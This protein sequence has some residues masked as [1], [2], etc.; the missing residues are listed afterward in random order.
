[1]TGL[2]LV[3]AVMNADV[4]P[5][6]ADVTIIQDSALVLVTADDLMALVSILP[7]GASETLF[8]DPESAAG[9]ALQHHALLTKLAVSHDL[10]PIRLGAIY[11]DGE[12]VKAML[13][14]SSVDF[15]AALKRIAG[16]AEFAMKLTP[17]GEAAISENPDPAISGRS[18]LQRRADQAAAQRNRTEQ[19]RQVASDA[20]QAVSSVALEHAFAPPRRNAQADQEKR[21]LDAA[22]LV[23]R[24]QTV[25]FEAAV[26]AAQAIAEKAGYRLTVTG[27]LPPYSFVGIAGVREIAA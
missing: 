27:P 1:M 4:S 12:A 9:I 13:R 3:H 18:Y 24:S 2:F 15:C 17:S 23:E 26:L 7:I 8:A 20:F 22:L 14:E 16:A 6:L 11:A 21:L 5:D 10:A 19:A 25:R